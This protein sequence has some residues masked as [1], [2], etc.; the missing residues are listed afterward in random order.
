MVRSGGILLDVKSKFES[1]I[2]TTSAIDLNLPAMDMLIVKV[3]SNFKTLYMIVIY[4]P[5]NYFE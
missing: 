5:S 4:L 2:L 1:K 3:V